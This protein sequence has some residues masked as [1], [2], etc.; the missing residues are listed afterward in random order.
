VNLSFL[1]GS[2]E[3]T[4]R[5]M[6]EDGGS[7]HWQHGSLGTAFLA[8]ACGRRPVETDRYLLTFEDNLDPPLRSHAAPGAFRLAAPEPWGRVTKGFAWFDR[9][10]LQG[11]FAG[12]IVGM[13]A[14]IHGYTYATGERKSSRPAHF[15]SRFLRACMSLLVNYLYRFGPYHLDAERRLLW[16]EETRIALQPK[17]FDLLLYMVRNPLRPLAKEELLQAVWPDSFVEE[18]NLTQN[19]FLLRKALTGRKDN[20]TRY[21]VTL[22]GRG[23]Q[24]V[25]PVDRLDPSAKDGEYAADEGDAVLTTVRSR[26]RI[27]VD[28]EVSATPELALPLAALPGGSWKAGYVW[29][30]VVAVVA[31][32]LA[33]VLHFRRPAGSGQRGSTNLVLADFENQTGD[34]TFDVVLRKALEIDLSQSPYLDV[35]SEQEAAGTLR[36]MGVDADT[37]LKSPVATEVCQRSNRQVVVRESIA[38]LGRD[39]VLTLQA[40]DCYSGKELAEAKAEASSREDVLGALDSAADSLRHGL[41]ESGQSIGQFQVPIAQASTS[42]LDALKAYSIGEYMVGRT[43]KDETETLPIFQRA[44]EFDPGF[45]MAYAAIA[46][47]YFNLGEISSARPYYQK[48][49]A[50]SDRVSEKEKLYIRA[51]Y[52]ADCQQDLE[53]GIKEYQLWADTYPR[54]WGPWL[55]IANEYT[56]L[57]QYDRAIA[58]GEHALALDPSRGISY[59]VLADGYL[60]A[61]RYSDAKSTALRGLSVGKG[62]PALHAI[63]YKV[64][65]V[66]H[67][68]AGMSGEIA[69]TRGAA[70]EWLA[71]SIQAEA[72]SSSGRYKESEELFRSAY[73]MAARENLTETAN[74]ILIDEAETEFY[75]GMPGAARATLQHLRRDYEENPK[76]VLLRM[77]LNESHVRERDAG[78]HDELNPPGTLMRYVYLP[79]FRAQGDL[80][81]S[82]AAE[83]LR[84]L[85]TATPYEFATG[86]SLIAE[87]ADAYRLSGDAEKAGL[88]YKAIIDHQGIDPTSPLLPLAHLWLA[89]ADAQLRQ[90]PA[91]K[92]EYEAFLTSWKGADPDLPVLV[93]AKREYAAVSAAS[94]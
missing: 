63:L 35:M 60:H 1:H 88:E 79:L 4:N 74:K 72:A 89:R 51:H 73:D 18:G 31:L 64:A 53:Q 28:E 48:A 29:T 50:L 91:S 37:S 22:P 9:R 62:S 93:T 41:G 5:G 13:V 58:A 25:S 2:V 87:R 27:V 12:L 10:A 92:G 75:L 80:Q 38:S 14:S 94:R 70:S 26:M 84:E 57:G 55:N 68:Q 71:L 11:W 23:Y 39:Y 78:G 42:S 17:T 20:D 81:R 67:D 47:D 66:E 49:F 3:R 52:Y 15:V 69:Q 83:A 16:R 85:D 45:A 33:T 46:K 43:A 7:F 76:L 44:V 21:I 8:I 34:K 6:S 82:H 19:I 32:G 54:D 77:K 90:V 56:L 59:S 61:G 24:F 36:L 40:L 65:F 30:A 86:Y